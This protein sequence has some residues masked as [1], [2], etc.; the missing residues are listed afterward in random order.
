MKYICERVNVLVTQSCLTLCD[1]MDYSLP[2]SSV[3]GI[4]QARILEWV[5]ISFT[6]GS[7]RPRLHTWVSCIA[8]SF[9]TV[10]ATREAQKYIQCVKTVIHSNLMYEHHLEEYGTVVT[11][12]SDLLPPSFI[13]F[14]NKQKTIATTKN[15]ETFNCFYIWSNEI[16]NV[17][18][19]VY[20]WKITV[21]PYNW[22]SGVNQRNLRVRIAHN[23]T[24]TTMQ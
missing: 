6:R 19:T 2:G 24:A 9:F 17:N 18:A 20:T 16:I 10:W 3:R 1:H 4:L 11:H 21:G 12:S 7:S 22:I 8:G 15:L 13:P 5:A 23:I 14:W